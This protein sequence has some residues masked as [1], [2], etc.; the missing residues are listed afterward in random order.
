MAQSTTENYW[1]LKMNFTQKFRYWLPVILAMVLIYWMSTGGF[2]SSNTSR[3]IEPIIRFFAPSISRK[4]I[5]MIHGVI[6]KLAHVTEYF[7]FGMLLFRAF[8]ADS[9]ERRWWTWGLSS[10]AVVV[11]YAAGDEMHQYFVSTRTA[12]PAD[13]GFDTLGGILAQY[14]SIVWYRQHREDGDP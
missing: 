7:I 10:L 6:R 2:S 3:I 4:Q 8:R 12:S 14:A 11:L 5:L 1:F 9:R 13:V